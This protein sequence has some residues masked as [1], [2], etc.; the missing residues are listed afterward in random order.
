MKKNKTCI[1]QPQEIDRSSNF[2]KPFVILNA[3]ADTMKHTVVHCLLHQVQKWFRFQPLKKN[4]FSE[5][6]GKLVRI[7]SG[8]VS[9]WEF[10]EFSAVLIY[11]HCHAQSHSSRHSN[12]R[13]YS[14][15]HILCQLSPFISNPNPTY[16]T[17]SYIQGINLELLNPGWSEH[18]INALTHRDFNKKHSIRNRHRVMVKQLRWLTLHGNKHFL[19]LR[20]R[21]SS[22]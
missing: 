18:Q 4:R 10:S 6:Q 11:S 8:W 21:N 19:K 14:R 9:R 2:N 16:P 3:I 7:E 12:S 20:F 22:S 13:A 5:K 15:K 17:T 1:C